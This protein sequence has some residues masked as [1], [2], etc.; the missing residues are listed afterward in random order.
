MKK[1]LTSDFFNRPTLE[2][3]KDLLGKYLVRKIIVDNQGKKVQTETEISLQINEVEAY[4][5]FKD[6]ASHAHHGITKRNEIMFGKAGHFY[7]YFVYGMHEMLNV[8]TGPVGYPAAILIRGAG[9]IIGPAK[10]TKFLQIERS[11][12]G[13]KAIPENGLWFEDKGEV[14]GKLDRR[15][16]I[17]L[18]RIGIA[19]AGTVWGSKLYRFV[20]RKKKEKVKELKKKG[21]EPEAQSR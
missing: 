6:M 2:V 3:A 17:K 12:N 1:I 13:K 16:I 14:M 8:V 19:Y 18:P 21:T 7:I 4:D 15:E 20:Y 9:E 5:G 10:L 11:L